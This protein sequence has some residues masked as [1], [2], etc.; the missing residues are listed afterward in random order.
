MLLPTLYLWVVD[1]LALRRGTWVIEAGTK[2]GWEIWDGL[3]IEYGRNSL[4]FKNKTDQTRREALFFLVTNLL[5]VFGLV[6][7]DNS[8]AILQSFPAKFPSLKAIPTFALLIQALLVRASEYDED[9]LAGFREAIQRLRNKS[10]SFYLASGVFEGRLRH[11][12]VLLYDAR[13]QFT[14]LN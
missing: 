7:F 5:I 11:D 2:L 10:R 4:S 9:R 3:E 14:E 13:N 8:V 6:A 12:L 1:T